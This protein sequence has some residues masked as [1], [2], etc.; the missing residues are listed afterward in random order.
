MKKRSIINAI[1]VVLA[2][3]LITFSSGLFYNGL[4]AYFAIDETVLF[5]DTQAKSKPMEQSMAFQS[6]FYS[7]IFSLVEDTEG[8]Y[9]RNEFNKETNEIKQQVV[10][11]FS[12]EY[13][14]QRASFIENYFINSLKT[15]NYAFPE[16]YF[17]TDVNYSVP[18]KTIRNKVEFVKDAPA[19]IRDVQTIVNGTKGTDF[20]N[21]ALLVPYEEL[22]S[23]H[24]EYSKEIII[25]NN[26]YSFSINDFLLLEDDVK[27][28]V[29]QRF[30]YYMEEICSEDFYDYHG[31]EYTNKDSFKFYVKNTKTGEITTNLEDENYKDL[32]EKPIFY[33]YNKGKTTTSKNTEYLLDDDIFCSKNFI[34]YV[35]IDVANAKTP[36]FYT[37]YDA[38]YTNL[39]TNGVSNDIIFGFVLFV[40]A[41]I[42]AIITLIRTK[43][44]RIFIDK[45]FTDVHLCLATLAVILVV[46]GLVSILDNN[47]YMMYNSISQDIVA[48]G[49]GLIFAIAMNFFCSLVRVCKSDKKIYENC[50]VFI[51]LKWLVKLFIKPI[52]KIKAL[53]SYKPAKLHKTVIINIV[54]ALLVDA[55]LGSFLLGFCV[56]GTPVFVLITTIVLAV[57]NIFLAYKWIE[58]LIHLDKIITC[59]VNRTDLENLEK[60]PESLK[61]LQ[62]SMKYTN[63]E[64][65]LAVEKAVKDERL[66]TELIT[67][68]SHDLKTPLTSIINYVDL[69]EKCDIKDKKAKEYIKV[70]DEKGL[71][72]KR[73]IDDL[74]EA[75][76]VSSG[77]ITLNLSHI[78]LSE[79]VVQAISEMEEEFNKSKLE[80]KCKLSENQPMI[81]ADGNKTFRVVENLLSNAKKYSAKGTRVY[82]EVYEENGFGVF[83]IKN[84]SALPLDISPDELTERFVRGDKSRTNEGNGLGLS[85]AKELCFAMGGK[86]EITIDG[87]LFKAKVVL[88]Q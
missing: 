75:S 83:E 58:Y 29:V 42:L 49:V 1:C 3:V 69:L 15:V 63:D 37:V 76:K 43:R 62:E 38:Y 21:Y 33:V 35:A 20:N 53:L 6:E 79:L 56:G 31:Y 44:E 30:T 13:L 80:I 41:I 61:V 9:L 8:E 34:C 87:D 84:V 86:L 25:G 4:R 65:R 40:I 24:F 81:F 12:A 52:K 72:L 60:L 73:L 14:K 10:D 17:R 2:I 77:N 78:N 47:A 5:D 71:K 82:V 16:E 68:V 28:E 39:Q 59:S 88:P 27:D 26:V 23:R 64:L 32:A 55:I 18:E 11:E 74:I 50:L 51:F 45:L 36:D 22:E 66:K 48:L 85:I 7:D 54:L 19:I 57:F 46:L 67:N 70:L